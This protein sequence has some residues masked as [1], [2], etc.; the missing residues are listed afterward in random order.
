[1]LNL[2]AIALQAASPARGLLPNIIMIGGMVAIFWFVLLRPQRKMRQQHEQ[3]LGGLKKGDEI[4]TD[5]GIIG[6]VVHLAED[7]LTLRTA[8][9]TRIVVARQKIAKVYPPTAA[10]E[11]KA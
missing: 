8:E 3:M 5:G 10:G 6:Q 2:F 9:N 1:M 7:R 11:T 4:M